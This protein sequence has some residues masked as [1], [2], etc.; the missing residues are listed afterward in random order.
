M[1]DPTPEAPKTQDAPPE[2]AEVASSMPIEFRSFIFDA[3]YKAGHAE[4]DKDKFNP[5]IDAGDVTT[6]R[7]KINEFLQN[8]YSTENGY[9]SPMKSI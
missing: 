6:I 9:I 8:A 4:K 5:V 3:I 7:A 1:T 2:A